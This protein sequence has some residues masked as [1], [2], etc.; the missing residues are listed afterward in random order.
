MSNNLKL[1]LETIFKIQLRLPRNKVSKLV[2]RDNF[3]NP[4]ERLFYWNCIKRLLWKFCRESPR[5]QQNWSDIL[6]GGQ[7][8]RG[9]GG[10]PWWKVPP[11]H[12]PQYW[13]TGLS[14]LTFVLIRYLD[15]AI[16]Q[17]LPPSSLL[18]F[19]TEA[20]SINCTF[21]L[22]YYKFLNHRQAKVTRVTKLG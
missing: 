8:L 9:G 12:P 16:V 13:I 7:V 11:P 22:Q 3:G 15:S 2:Y 5:R 18:L 20:Q 1:S 14:N 21:T 4:V 10:W 6:G 19:C 17:V